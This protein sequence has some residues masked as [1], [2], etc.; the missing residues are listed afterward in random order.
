MQPCYTYTVLNDIDFKGTVIDRE[1]NNIRIVGNNHKFTNLR[2]QCTTSASCSINATRKNFISGLVLNDSHIENL[3][4]T[5]SSDVS[6]FPDIAEAFSGLRLIDLSRSTLQNISVVW[7]ISGNVKTNQLFN[8]Q[9]FM[10]MSASQSQV[11]GFDA[12]VTSR[13][14]FEGGS[15]SKIRFLSTLFTLVET[16]LKTIQ[17]Q[18]ISEYTFIAGSAT[19]SHQIYSEGLRLDRSKIY[20]VTIRQELVSTQNKFQHL[21]LESCT[22]AK[23]SELKNVNL[24]YSSKMTPTS[25]K[26]I[27]EASGYLDLEKFLLFENV[28]NTWTAIP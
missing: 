26:L 9:F 20:D 5:F 8:R 22:N 12:A 17:V 1:L 10:L 27:S 7:N 4:L 15:A 11:N 3:Q 23:L 2:M 16:T 28:N 18:V 13:V 6:L 21:N 19:D 14:S 24:A 25:F